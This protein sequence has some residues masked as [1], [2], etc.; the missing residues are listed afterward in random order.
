MEIN[1]A[2]QPSGVMM[3][4]LVGR[5]DI[6]GAARIDVQF[7]AVAA[8]S[9]AVVVDMGAVTFMASMGLRTLLLA[10]KAMR[11]KAGRMVLYRPQGDV[12]AVLVTSGTSQLV[13]VS[14]D[15][16]AA[17]QLALGAAAG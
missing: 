4:T 2:M 3:I 10:A 12:E 15:L 8:S 16:A 13:P 5:L 14:H 17:E 9:A 1:F 6:Q 7:S 11:G